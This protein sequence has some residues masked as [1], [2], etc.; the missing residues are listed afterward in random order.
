[1]Q[2]VLSR[3]LPDSTHAQEP[4]QRRGSPAGRGIDAE[5]DDL[6]W[7]VFVTDGNDRTEPVESMP[8]VVR[9]LVDRVAREAETA[10]ELGI[11]AIALF[12]K[13]RRN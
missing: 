11:P 9:C 10:A 13:P 4:R 8:G 7:P 2:N 3:P 6:I 5:P 12:R 1:M